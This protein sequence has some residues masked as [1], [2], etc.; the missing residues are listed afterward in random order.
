MRVLALAKRYDCLELT[1]DGIGHDGAI[2]AGPLLLLTSAI[3]HVLRA[4][5]SG[6][7]YKLRRG[8]AVAFNHLCADALA[9]M[10]S[11]MGTLCKPA[12]TTEQLVE[13]C[14]CLERLALDDGN[15]AIKSRMIQEF[16]LFL[17]VRVNGSRCG[18]VWRHPS[19]FVTVDVGLQT[20]PHFRTEESSRLYEQFEKLEGAMST[21]ILNA[22]AITGRHMSCD[23]QTTDDSHADQQNGPPARKW[24]SPRNTS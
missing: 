10:S 22:H 20:S 4:Q 1:M 6:A 7:L 12:S 19:S 5:P 17:K 21:A 14:E 8:V 24:A 9:S 16:H 13:M 3:R 18:L 15:L 23:G 2:T 11:V